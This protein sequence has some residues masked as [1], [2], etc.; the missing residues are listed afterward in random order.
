MNTKLLLMYVITCI[1]FSSCIVF[2][3]SEMKISLSKSPTYEGETLTVTVTSETNALSGVDVEFAETTAQTDSNGEATFT[4]PD[5]G[6]ESAV[7]TIVAEKAGYTTMETPIT[8]IKIYDVH[9]AAPSTPPKTGEKFNITI[10][11]KGAPLKGAIVTFNGRTYTSNQDGKITITS[12][13]NPGNYKLIASYENYQSD[14]IEITVQSSTNYENNTYFY[15]SFSVI[16]IIVIS[17]IIL[18]RIR[19]NKKSIIKKTSNSRKEYKSQYKNRENPL[20][21]KNNG[22]KILINKKTMIINKLNALLDKEQDLQVDEIKNLINNNQIENAEN[23][24]DKIINKYNNYQKTNDELKNVKEKISSL[25]NR[26]ADGDLSSEA[27]SMAHSE[28]ERKKKEIEEKL[29][30]LRNKLFK[31]DYEKPF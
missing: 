26:V 14:E 5:P 31:D 16:G 12:P 24:L 15:I 18:I 10:I 3:D 4:V 28:L 25:T 7:Y 6:V 23:K 27:F 30:K 21:E 13:N 1:I 2:A 11:A 22:N 19:H 29:W 20:L 17:L 9:I 8:V